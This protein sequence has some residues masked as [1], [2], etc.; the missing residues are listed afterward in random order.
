MHRALR[1]AQLEHQAGV[2][3]TYFIYPH[4]LF[5]NLLSRSIVDMVK[6]IS[7]LGHD[8]G[9]HFDPKFYKILTL[10]LII[11]KIISTEKGLVETFIDISPKAISFIYMVF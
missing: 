10:K 2:V 1:L 8:I 6:E 4:S 3:S 5:Y 11:L 7:K 9:L